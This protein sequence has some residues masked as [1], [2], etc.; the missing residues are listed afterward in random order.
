MDELQELISSHAVSIESSALELHD[1]KKRLSV[2]DERI[3]SELN[4]RML[5]VLEKALVSG[6]YRC[7]KKWLSWKS[8]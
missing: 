1:M 8:R 2:L 5:Q 4:D 7:E 3:G 6:G